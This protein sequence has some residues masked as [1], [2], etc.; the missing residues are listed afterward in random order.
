MPREIF[1]IENHLFSFYDQPDLLSRICSDYLEWLKKVID[2]IGNVFTFDFMSFAEDMSYNLGPMLSKDSFDKFLAPY[3][4]EI[5]PL[6]KEFN[7]AVFIDS[8]GD[9]TQAVD[10]YSEVGADG[11]FPLERQAGVDV[12]LY[13]KKH[14]EMTF[15]GHFDKM[16]MHNG[17][18]ALRTEFE[19]LMPSARKGKLIISVD[20]QTPPSVS[21]KDYK[22]YIKLFNEYARKI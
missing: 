3:Y 20:H 7:I 9:I 4:K 21:Y 16:I 5:I 14:P 22:L 15:L 8:D 17:E 2:Y 18:V 1:G 19:R 12:S 11:M 6:I 10:W 13:I